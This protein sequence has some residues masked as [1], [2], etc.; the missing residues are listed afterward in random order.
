MTKPRD[1][2]K[3][4]DP[5]NKV[6]LDPKSTPAQLE[7]ELSRVQRVAVTKKPDETPAVVKYRHEESGG[8]SWHIESPDF[9]SEIQHG[10][11]L[12]F[13]G[14]TMADD[15]GG[16]LRVSEHVECTTI[17]ASDLAGREEFD[18][19]R[20]YRVKSTGTEVVFKRLDPKTGKPIVWS[21][22]TG[23][24]II[25]GNGME[26]IRTDRTARPTA[27][28]GGQMTQKNLAAY[29]IG[30][31]PAI[32]ATQLTQ[33][34]RD[35]FPQLQVGDRHGPHYLSLSRTGRLAEAPTTDPRTWGK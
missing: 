17:R 25:V 4:I 12:P 15:E 28:N 5:A 8:F 16:T 11:E 30:Q 24:E 3:I 32:S 29:L 26:M 10:K 22:G 31:N 20:I 1:K 34:L 35:A 7:R 9:Y 2:I 6:A 33:E 27:R 18:Q 14:I 19:R 13:I 21:F 23:M